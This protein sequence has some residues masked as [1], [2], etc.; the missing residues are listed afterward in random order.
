M[1]FGHY[2]FYEQNDSIR[3]SD[4]ATTELI[5]NYLQTE[6]YEKK[7]ISLDVNDWTLMT[8]TNLPLQNNNSDCGVLVCAYA[9][10]I[11]AN[12]LIEFSCSS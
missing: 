2:R 7:N 5:F 3:A 12:R 11:T 10:A 6:S 8:K 9:E 1:V 4:R